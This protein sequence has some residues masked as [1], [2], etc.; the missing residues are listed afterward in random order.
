MIDKTIDYE[1][2]FIVLSNDNK[3]AYK[4]F[5]TPLRLMKTKSFVDIGSKNDICNKYIETG[6]VNLKYEHKGS[7][8]NISEYGNFDLNT[9]FRDPIKVILESKKSISKCKYYV[10]VHPGK[11]NIIFSGIILFWIPFFLTYANIFLP[12]VTKFKS[13]KIGR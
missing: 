3:T 7:M 5:Y 9:K 1:D 4:I 2:S 6:V 8:H 12:I 10:T 11:F 13:R